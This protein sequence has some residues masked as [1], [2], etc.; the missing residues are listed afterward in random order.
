VYST[1][2][3]RMNGARITSRIAAIIR[4]RRIQNCVEI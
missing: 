2:P 4:R 1:M 3:S